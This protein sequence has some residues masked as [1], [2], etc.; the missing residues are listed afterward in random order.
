MLDSIL[1]VFSS[2]TEKDKQ[3]SDLEGMD[4]HQLADIGISRDQIEAFASKHTPEE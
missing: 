4:D 1:E 2:E 3:I